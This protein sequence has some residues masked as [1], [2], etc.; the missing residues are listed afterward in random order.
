MGIKRH[1]KLEVRE[2]NLV[3]SDKRQQMEIQRRQNRERG[4]RGHKQKQKVDQLYSGKTL[5]KIESVNDDE[6]PLTIFGA[7]VPSLLA[8]EF[9]LPWLTTT[10]D[11]RREKSQRRSDTR[12]S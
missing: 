12:R 4:E 7:Q 1:A 8:T 2:R 10:E 6:I 11:L 9:K 5:I 3:N